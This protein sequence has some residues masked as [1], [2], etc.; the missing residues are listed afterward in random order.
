MLHQARRIN[1]PDDYKPARPQE[2]ER[3]LLNLQ[4]AV[5]VAH[6]H[7][8]AGPRGRELNSVS[9]GGARGVSDTFASALW[10][11]DTLFNMAAV[12][13]DGVNIHTFNKALDQPSLTHS[14]GGWQAHVD[15]M[16]YGTPTFARAAPTGSAHPL[17]QR[18]VEPSAQDLGTPSARRDR[19]DRCGQRLA[20]QTAGTGGPTAPPQRS[21]N[22]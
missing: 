4:A 22:S 3:R 11:L 1:L 20:N 15:P 18:Y 7:G 6:I 13:V 21:R 16:D 12:G 9:C 2:L 5:H 8:L 19:S 17:D 10:I 14:S